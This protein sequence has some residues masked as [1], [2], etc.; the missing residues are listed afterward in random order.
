VQV[1]R[2][3]GARRVV[4][5]GASLGGAVALKTAHAVRPPPAGLIS[6]SGELTL[7]GGF[8]AKPGLRRWQGP[9]L[10]LGSA[11]D[12]FFTA[13]DARLAARVHPGPET[14]VSVPGTAHGVDLLDPEEDPR[15]AQV[16]AA[17]SRFLARTL[18][19]G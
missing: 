5:A 9:L 16:R 18:G 19:A 8:D 7:R 1:L 15:A 12:G 3:Q 13:A 11:R 10:L 6:F 4:L 2:D 14:V 17:V